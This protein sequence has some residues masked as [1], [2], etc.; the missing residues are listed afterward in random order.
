MGFGTSRSPPTAISPCASGGRHA[1]Q[2][3]ADN[4]WF[5]G[6]FGTQFMIF[7]FV[8]LFLAAVGLYGVMAFSV[9]RQTQEVD[10]LDGAGRARL[11][12]AEADVL[13]AVASGR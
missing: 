8:A 5:Y 3:I 4:T 7:G 10:V 1:K 9:S 6:V 2:G 13:S 11:G 12:R